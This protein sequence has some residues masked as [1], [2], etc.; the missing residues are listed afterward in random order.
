MRFGAQ[1]YEILIM[2]I[3]PADSNGNNV[4]VEIFTQGIPLPI[5]KQLGKR[6]KDNCSIE[7]EVPD[8]LLLYI[9]FN[10]KKEVVFIGI[11]LL[12]K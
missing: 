5:F 12:R 9:S 1:T 2:P 10:D 3:K 7:V 8:K 6:S 4:E 11:N